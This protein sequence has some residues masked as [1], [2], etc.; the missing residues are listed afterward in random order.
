MQINDRYDVLAGYD[1]G[2]LNLVFTL[3]LL[4]TSMS[5]KFRRF[6]TE[7]LNWRRL[8]RMNRAQPRDCGLSMFVP[9]QHSP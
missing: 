7:C 3:G 2:A 9:V 6:V 4:V 5:N 1:G 8:P